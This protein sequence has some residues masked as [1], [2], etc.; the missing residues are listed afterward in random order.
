MRLILIFLTT[1]LLGSGVSAQLRKCIAPDGKVT[2]SDVLCNS[3]ATTGTIKNPMGN[4]L[5]TSGLRQEIQNNRVEKDA[6]QSK[7]KAIAQ[8]SP[9]QE[10]TF[11]FFSIGDEKGKRLAANAKTE[12]LQNNAARLNG[13]P[14]SL[15]HYTFWNDHHSRKSSNRQAAIT[16]ANSDTNA[17]MTRGAIDDAA[18]KS[19]NKTT[20]CRPNFSGTGFDCN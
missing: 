2:Y 14:T 19:K 17:L 5:D 10:C 18:S 9:A 6:A 7:A 1:L 4:S 8:Q 11:S 12:C 15:E 3:S 16:R 20:N 13:E